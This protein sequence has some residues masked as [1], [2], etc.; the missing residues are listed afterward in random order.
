MY[1][2]S[3]KAAEK[4]KLV[5]N[6]ALWAKLTHALRIVVPLDQGVAEGRLLGKK[7]LWCSQF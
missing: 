4:E 1:K 5:L 2:S 7:V 3:P 6:E